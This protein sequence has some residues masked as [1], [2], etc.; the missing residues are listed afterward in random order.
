M[1]VGSLLCVLG[2]WRLLAHMLIRVHTHTSMSLMCPHVH[3]SVCETGVGGMLT[4]CAG[5]SVLKAVDPA[6]QLRAGT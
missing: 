2:E 5:S 6:V 1:E 4:S 3:M